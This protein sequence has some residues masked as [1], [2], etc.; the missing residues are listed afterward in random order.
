MVNPRRRALTLAVAFAVLLSTSCGDGNDASSSS[1]SALEDLKGILATTLE[2]DLLFNVSLG[3]VDDSQGAEAKLVGSGG[4]SSSGA[5]FM[6]LG[7]ETAPTTQAVVSGDG[8]TAHRVDAEPWQLAE[9][10]ESSVADSPL[11][12]VDLGDFAG[13]DRIGLRELTA[14]SDTGRDFELQVRSVDALDLISPI[15]EETYQTGGPLARV[16]SLTVTYST[17]GRVLESLRVTGW[18]PTGE[19]DVG[20][21]FQEIRIE[22]KPTA[23]TLAQEV[24]DSLSPPPAIMGRL[25]SELGPAPEA[26]VDEEAQVDTASAVVLADPP[27]GSAALRGVA[28]IQP[29]SRCGGQERGRLGL[30][31]LSI[32]GTASSFTVPGIQL[33][34]TGGIV[35]AGEFVA[36]AAAGLSGGILLG[37]GLLMAGVG[38]YL[39]YWTIW[40]CECEQDSSGFVCLGQAVA[41]AAGRAAALIDGATGLS[42]N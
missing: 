24:Q 16:G 8:F 11:S 30:L 19:S 29:A 37:V 4:F 5:Y 40:G 32:F 12:S 39:L 10:Y 1:A 17:D 13:D 15:V 2:S 28:W 21:Q 34:A 31:S 26:G 38:A 7:G 22:L 20:P 25:D 35:S 42:D 18:A 3:I 41:G 27:G 6:I 33:V 36:V 23:R 9:T 14:A